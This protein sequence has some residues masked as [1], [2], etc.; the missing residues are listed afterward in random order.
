VYGPINAGSPKYVA[1]DAAEFIAVQAKPPILWIRGSDDMIVSDNS[2]FDF[3]ALGKL[4]FVPDWPGDD[5]YPPQPMIS[6]TRAVLEKYAAN[7]GS[8][9]EH[10]I[11]D[12]AHG[13]HIEKP[14]EFN[15]LFH[16]FLT[17]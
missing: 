9:E 8:Y 4:G 17:V 1:D 5:V 6:Q 10:V 11:A 7:G 16:P 3:G 12:T 2:M 13:P 15:L 14:D